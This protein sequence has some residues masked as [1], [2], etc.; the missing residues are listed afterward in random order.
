MSL[1]LIEVTIPA[2]RKKTLEHIA[3]NY[4]AIDIWCTPK[5]DDGQRTMSILCERDSQQDILDS[6]QTNLKDENDWR[7]VLLPVEATIPKIETVDNDDNDNE[8]SKKI[9]WRKS[10]SREELYQE[11]AGGA[12]SNPLYYMMVLLS[13]IVA[14]I[15]LIQDNLA[16]VIAAMVIAPLLGPNLAL[17]FGTSL[18]EKRLILSALKTNAGGL[19]AAV[20]PCIVLGYFLDNGIQSEQLMDRT[21][22]DFA[23]IFV[24]LASG[25]AA[26]LSMTT[27][28][29]SALVGVMVS[30]ALLPPAAALGIFIGMQRFDDAQSSF[31]LLVTNIVCIG[32]SSQIVL[33]IMGIRPRTFLEKRKALQSSTVQ[34]G[35]CVLLLIII[36]IIIFYSDNNV[37]EAVKD[38]ADKAKESVGG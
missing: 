28:V 16:F 33:A 7:A 34:A 32:L 25:A 11:V 24:A 15:G 17:A 30:V 9:H 36:S 14:A 18:G 27:G 10:L 37:G 22:I 20:L 35:V 26:V 19:V 5:N 1:R 2:E 4:K 13:T 8:K 38:A 23:A 6:I 21:V 12:E 3:D 31:L 29:S